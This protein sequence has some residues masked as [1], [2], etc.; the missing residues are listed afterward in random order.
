MESSSRVETRGVLDELRPG[1]VI[2]LAEHLGRRIHDHDGQDERRPKVRALSLDLTHHHR[3]LEVQSDASVG[4][5]PVAAGQLHAGHAEPLVAVALEEHQELHSGA[6]VGDHSAGRLVVH[7]GVV[8]AVAIGTLLFG[9]PLLVTQVD[10]DLGTLGP[11][12]DHCCRYHHISVGQFGSWH[13]S[14]PFW[15]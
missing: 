5:D 1:E 8:L 10:A 9:G 4:A 15:V 14:L 11:E 13:L 2:F 7:E 12:G 6:Q 3:A